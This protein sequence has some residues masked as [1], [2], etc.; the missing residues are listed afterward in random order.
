MRTLLSWAAILWFTAAAAP[1]AFAEERV[2]VVGTKQAPPFVIKDEQGQFSG[3]SIELWKMA[4]ERLGIQYRIEERELDELINGLRRGELDLSV[5]ALTATPGREAVIDFSHPFYTTGYGI[6]VPS[7]GNS[8]W[9]AVKRFFSWEF[10]TALAA[11]TGILLLAG[12]LLWLAERRRN[13][14]MFGG[15][16]RE[17]IGSSFWWAAVTMTTV[18]YG[19]KA[20]IT[21][22]GRVVALVWMFASIIIISSFTAAIATSLTVSH[23]ETKISNLEDLREVRVAT[24]PNSSSAAFLDELDISYVADS[25]TLE[26]NL[27]ALVDG[28]V[29]AVVYDAPILQYSVKTKFRN[30]VSV[31]EKTFERQDYAL[32]LPSGSTLREPLNREIL[33]ILGSEPWQ[34]LLQRYL[35]ARS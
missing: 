5:A 24:V 23:L 31:L 19:D 8:V 7:R 20:P 17:G 33:E 10:F 29:D 14:D 6:A 25:G 2:L 1:S 35:D 9:L 22:A 34:K 13:P 28:Q 30:D 11:L 12:F 4:A 18:G 32:A 21:F 16:R 26:D 15:S 3:I 27:R